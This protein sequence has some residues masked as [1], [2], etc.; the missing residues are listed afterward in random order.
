RLEDVPHVR[1]GQPARVETAA[2]PGGVDGEVLFA[3]S[4]ADVQKNT[5]QVKVAV[6]EPPAVL[7]PDM[8]VQVT[9]LA[10]PA[11]GGKSE[12][13][14]ALRLLVPRPL[15]E[16]GGGG[17]RVWVVDQAAGVAR[18]RAVKLGAGARGDLIEVAE[19]LTA[20]DRL[21]SGGREGLSEGQRVKIAGEDAA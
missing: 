21:I 14:E 1:P 4:Q 12:G 15:V 13:G 2:V 3:T 7:K 6:K 18:R 8:L 11:A 19:G 16:A 5:L 9:F 10:P 17:A 20:G